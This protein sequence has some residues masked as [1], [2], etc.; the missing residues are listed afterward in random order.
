MT[1]LKS[2]QKE[3]SDLLADLFTSSAR[4]TVLRVF[5]LDPTRAYYQR[6]LEGATGLPIRAVQRELERLSG[7]GLLYRRTEGNRAYYQ[8]DR[9]FLLYPE[10]RTMVLKV[11]TPVEAL[12][13]A[14]S[15]DESIRLAFL[16]ETGDEVLAVFHPGR[17]P[18]V[19][20]PEGISVELHSSEAFLAALAEEAAWLD[21]YLRHGADLL[22]RRDDVIWRHI[23]AA[24]HEVP[25]G[26][27]VP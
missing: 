12:R 4:S 2:S 14:L 8:V 3:H 27:G 24:G 6:Q 9:D 19:A 11:G 20:A 25:K 15:L 23:H 7:V 22:G 5:M 13:G 10:L 21:P 16:S 17:R 18:A 1:T 26:D